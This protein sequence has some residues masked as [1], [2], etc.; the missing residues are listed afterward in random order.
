MNW[1][2][3]AVSAAVTIVALWLAGS[4]AQAQ[5]D[6]VDTAPLKKLVEERAGGNEAA[7]GS[8]KR[9]DSISD[10]TDDL[11]SQYRTILKQID[12]IDQYNRQMRTLIHA[13]QDEI[14][15]LASQLSGIQG[16]GR[17]VTPLMARM[18][19][20][21]AKF[22]DLDVPFLIEERQKRIAELRATMNRADVTS[23]EKFRQVMESYQIENEYGRTIEAYRGTL[24]LDGNESTVDFLR[25]GR[26]SLV[27]QS[28][29]ESIQGR[30]DQASRSWVPLD[31]SFRSSLRNGLRIARKQSAPDLI[32]LPLAA[33][34]NEK[35]AS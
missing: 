9:V 26:I 30:W 35:G 12:S 34:V 4:I 29:D 3:P 16:V 2:R 13:Q 6:V 28:L 1:S 27:Y 20:A 8:Q 17:S 25:F 14:E 10:E 32:R 15:S 33:A 7:A 5:D 31:S 24:T 11:Q 19:D 18:V 23:A 22:V 21:I